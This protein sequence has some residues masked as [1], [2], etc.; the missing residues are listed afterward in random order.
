[1]TINNWA[2]YTYNLSLHRPI[3]ARGAH[4][5]KRTGFVIIRRLAQSWGFG[6]A[7]P[8]EGFHPHTS[9]EIHTAL[10]HHL[11]NPSS[12]KIPPPIVQC[13][14]EMS[15]TPQMDIAGH[16]SLNGLITD[17]HTIDPQF[18]C[19]KIKV[20]RRPVLEDCRYLLEIAKRLPEHIPLRL[21]ANRAWSLK[22]S[23]IFWEGIEDIHHRI[24]YIEEPLRELDQLRHTHLPIALDENLLHWSEQLDK[25]NNL[26]AIILK[27]SLIGF[28]ATHAW[29]ERCKK[30]NIQ[31]VVSSTFE[32]SIG[33]F[34]FASL[35]MLQSDSHAGLATGSWFQEDL[36]KHRAL[37]IKG[38]LHLRALTLDDIL[39]EH[40][41]LIAHD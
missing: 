16:I 35:A 2:L 33:L 15:M 40:L 9:E 36:C 30:H 7:A 23:L 34:S 25:L 29:L 26:K 21:D 32:S 17:I 38:R 4:R 24:S 37:P 6:E 20:G 12:T 8:I 13:A 41:T 18:S 27:P 1:M 5:Y 22:D 39:F 31:A 19:Y 11:K 3:A 28:N 14:L 10:L